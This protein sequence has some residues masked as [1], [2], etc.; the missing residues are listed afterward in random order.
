MEVIC[1]PRRIQTLALKWKARGRR[2]AFV[3]TMGF[4]H[5]G[6]LSLLRAA[7]AAAD[8]VVVSI[9]VNPTQF[10]PREDFKSYPR[11]LKGDLDLCRKERVDAI[12]APATKDIYPRGF[13]TFVEETDLSRV[14]CGASRPGH[15]RGV[16]T[17]VAKLFN[18]VQPDLAFFGAKD[19]LQS[20][21]VLR[22]VRDL[23]FPVKVEVLP[24]VREKD[25]LALSSRNRNL[26]GEARQQALCLYR[27]LIM[28]RELV[29][30]GE[31]SAGKIKA[32]MKRLIRKQPLARIDY[33]EI[34][35]GET[36]QPQCR[37][38]RRSVAALAV[39]VGRTRLI[40][41]LS[42]RP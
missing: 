18:L 42:L 39:F 19:F 23:N 13:S 11:D 16:A 5:E 10:G 28:A 35:D 36:L 6:H 30:E 27:S 4:L 33:V 15:F 17:V 12:F 24:T 22:M 1:S 32:V 40:D 31:R 25:G 2:I 38:D 37:I 34:F 14:L 3:P 41:N 21:V 26:K 9:F 8:V 20:R 29:R 7:R